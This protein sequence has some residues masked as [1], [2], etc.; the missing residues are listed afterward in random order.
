MIL[1]R[2]PPTLVCLPL[3]LH[4][5][6]HLTIPRRIHRH[7]LIIAEVLCSGPFWFSNILSLGVQRTITVVNWAATSIGL[8]LDH[9]SGVDPDSN[10]NVV[11]V[12][13]RAVLVDDVAGAVLHFAV[14]GGKVAV[15]EAVEPEAAVPAITADL[16][17]AAAADTATCDVAVRVGL[18]VYGFSVVTDDR[19]VVGVADDT[20]TEGRSGCAVGTR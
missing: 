3:I 2:V 7:H 20:A 1:L 19:E 16:E 17:G 5:P 8:E 6:Q 18:G 15:G 13:R 4:G 11:G 10:A 12:F 14:F 9:A